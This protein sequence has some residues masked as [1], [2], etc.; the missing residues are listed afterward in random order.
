MLDMCKYNMA[1]QQNSTTPS[2]LFKGL[3]RAILNMFIQVGVTWPDTQVIQAYKHMRKQI[4]L[5]TDTRK[6]EGLMKPVYLH[7]ALHGSESPPG[8][9]VTHRRRGLHKT[10]QRGRCCRLKTV[11]KATWVQRYSAR[12]T[13]D[14]TIHAHSQEGSGVIAASQLWLLAKLSYE[15]PLVK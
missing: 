5:S 13:T 11:I 10:R 2:T 4:S 6:K 12:L 7:R 15:T 9:Q 1:S 14:P 3:R 8:W